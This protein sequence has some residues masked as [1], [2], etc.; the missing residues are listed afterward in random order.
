MLS[1]LDW[2]HV[3]AQQ[4][5]QREVEVIERTLHEHGSASGW[6]GSCARASGVPAASARS[7]VRPSRSAAQ[8]AWNALAM[9]HRADAVADERRVVAS[10]GA[11]GD[12][13]VHMTPVTIDAGPREG[14]AATIA[15]EPWFPTG[16][17]RARSCR[18]LAD[19]H[20]GADCDH[21]SWELAQGGAMDASGNRRRGRRR[22]TGDRP[23]HRALSAHR[24][25][26]RPVQNLSTV[27]LCA[28]TTRSPE[29]GAR[30]DDDRHLPRF[31]QQGLTGAQVPSPDCSGGDLVTSDRPCS[32]V[33]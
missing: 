29:D 23:S 21:R 1:R 26:G 14:W 19:P 9:E 17:H 30:G 5:F 15:T 31:A 8:H 16:R 10:A 4:A 28:S 25:R 2:A 6:R 32:R 13:A 18:A 33:S 7:C 3:E 11:R 27:S 22:R 20:R 24:A 12:L